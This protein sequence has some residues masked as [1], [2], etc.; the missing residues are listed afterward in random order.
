MALPGI[1]TA[2]VLSIGRIV[3]ESAALLYTA[4]SSM[5]MPR[6]GYMSGGGTF[7]V[8]I[9]KLATEGRT[10][11]ERNQAFAVAFILILLVVIIYVGLGLIEYFSK[12]EKG[13]KKHK[14][15]IKPPEVTA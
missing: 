1:L 10:T 13:Q 2:A 15:K 4:G 3:G 6:S 7:A 8:L 14:E 9:Y 12:K 5:L 11:Q